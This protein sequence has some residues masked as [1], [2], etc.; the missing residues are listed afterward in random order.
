MVGIGGV[1]MS[2]IAEILLDRGLDVSGSDVAPSAAVDRLRAAGATV[3]VGHAARQVGPADLLIASSAVPADNPEIAEAERRAIPVVGRGAMLAELAASRRT[4]AVAGSHGKTTTTS[5]IA[6]ALEAAGVDPTAVI[7]G[8]VRSL[9]GNARV[10]HGPFMVVEADESDRS[11]LHLSPEIAVITSVDDEHL[12]TYGGMRELEAAFAAF[13]ARVPPAG[14]VV[15]CADDARLGRLLRAA[16]APTLAYGIDEPSAAVRARGVTLAATGSRCRVAVR[17]G[18]RQ[19][20]VELAL[21]VPGRHNLQNALAALAVAVRLHLPLAPVAAALARFEGADRRFEPHGE[22]GGVRVID[23]YGHHP[24]EVAAAIETARLGAPGRVVVV[25]QPH[26]YTRTLRL[27]ER[28]GPALALADTVI[29]TPVH[30]AGEPPVAGATSRAIAAA[31]EAVSTIPV[32]CVDSLDGAV[33]A[34]LRTLCPGDVVLTLGAGTVGTIAPRIVRS[35]AA[36]EA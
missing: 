24:T 15:A 32:H 17:G 1:G 35:L 26:R 29:L 22:A 4:V 25:F 6:V 36:R 31:V 8:R 28:F 34:V 11:F 33:D 14:C 20:E 30:A 16:P 18:P 21:C 27:R 13:A 5:M 12:D 23:D 7:G 19:D 2:A 9:G 10:G 3:S